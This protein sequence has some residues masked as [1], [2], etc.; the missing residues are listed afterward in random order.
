[1][2]GEVC[3]RCFGS[4][5]YSKIEIFGYGILFVANIVHD[6]ISIH[7]LISKLIPGNFSIPVKPVD[8]DC[9]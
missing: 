8:V 6:Q 7:S 4:I 3:S 1:M 5:I 9:G 2:K